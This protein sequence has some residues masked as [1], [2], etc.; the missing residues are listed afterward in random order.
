MPP[1]ARG[2]TRC[3]APAT[4]GGRR[5]IQG[6]AWTAETGVR[7][8]RSKAY[9]PDEAGSWERR[10]FEPGPP[11]FPAFTA[12]ALRYG[13]NICTELWAMESVARYPSL[14]VEA[15]LTPRATAL[16]TT[17]RWMNLA[18]TVAVRT[19]AFSLSSNRRHSDGS[20]GGVGWIVDPEGREIARTSEAEPFITR[21]VDLAEAARARSAYPRYVFD[22]RP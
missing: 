18:K 20:C 6:F 13:L 22:E 1:L 11:E 15:I 4:E 8:L 21:E 19:G 5:R 2:R 12:G 16:A 14:G 9:L 7:P 17:E 3:P 10:W